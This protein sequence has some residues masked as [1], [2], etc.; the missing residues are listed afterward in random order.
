[1][2]RK[3]ESGFRHNPGIERLAL[4]WAPRISTRSSFDAR[5]LFFFF[6]ISGF[7]CRRK[8]RKINVRI[9]EKS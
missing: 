7:H 2:V 8:I 9:A 1:M 4:C 3:P 6:S 5:F